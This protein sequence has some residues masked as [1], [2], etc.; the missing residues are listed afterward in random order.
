MAN[1]EDLPF[2][3]FAAFDAATYRDFVG[4]RAELPGDLN[5]DGR[6]DLDDA[7]LAADTF[8]DASG[9]RVDRSNNFLDLDLAADVLDDGF[10]NGSAANFFGT[11]TAGRYAA[12]DSFDDIASSAGT[13]GADGV[14]DTGDFTLEEAVLLSLGTAGP[15]TAAAL[16]GQ[17]A[18]DADRDGD[19]D[20]DDLRLALGVDGFGL[21]SSFDPTAFY[22][23]IYG[24]PVPEP[25]AAAVLALGGLTLLRRRRAA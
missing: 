23:A 21:A 1:A 11:A 17:P 8:V 13:T 14:I 5:A 9:S 12:G 18:V 25:T 22:T 10:V 6:L 4:I 7:R 16:L 2:Y 20:G 24:V 19:V 15:A 3:A